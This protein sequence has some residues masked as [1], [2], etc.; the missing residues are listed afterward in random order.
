M[1]PSIHENGNERKR[2]AFRSFVRSN[3]APNQVGWFEIHCF[4]AYHGLKYIVCTELGSRIESNQNVSHWNHW[5][6]WIYHRRRHRL[7][8]LF[9]FFKKKIGRNLFHPNIQKK[10][11]RKNVRIHFDK[12]KLVWLWSDQQWKKVFC[13]NVAAARLTANRPGLRSFHA[14]TNICKIW[15]QMRTRTQFWIL[16]LA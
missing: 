3:A 2:N 12:S 16:L 8:F 6:H 14:E 4:M 11:G 5:N 7:P 15:K 13:F 1:I 9:W 10:S